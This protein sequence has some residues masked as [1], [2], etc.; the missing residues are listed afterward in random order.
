MQLSL[1]IHSLRPDEH[2]TE[3][4]LIFIMGEE[5]LNLGINVDNK[6]ELGETQPDKFVEAMPDGFY[7]PFKLAINP[8]NANRKS[9]YIDEEHI[10]EPYGLHGWMLGLQASGRLDT[11][12]AESMISR[13]FTTC[14]L[15]V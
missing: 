13:V 15:N 2:N 7:N 5:I 12:S 14:Y 4:L 6:V 11:P 8:L 9:V 3:S 10:Q 1:C